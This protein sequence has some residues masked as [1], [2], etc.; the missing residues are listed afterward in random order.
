MRPNFPD[1]SADA[2]DWPLT[3]NGYTVAW[4]RDGDAHVAVATSPAGE[5]HEARGRNPHAV[6]CALAELCGVELEDG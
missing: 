1:T 6:V 3:A 5:R 2:V 4:S